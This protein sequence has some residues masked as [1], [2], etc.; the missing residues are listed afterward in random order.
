MVHVKFPEGK[1]RMVAFPEFWPNGAEVREVAE[2][3]FE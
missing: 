1:R 2:E 3:S